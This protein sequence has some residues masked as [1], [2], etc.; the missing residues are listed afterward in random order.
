VNHKYKLYNWHLEGNYQLDDMSVLAE[1]KEQALTLALA[2][3]NEL[4]AEAIQR[5]KANG[6]PPLLYTYDDLIVTLLIDDNL[7]IHS[8]P[9]ALYNHYDG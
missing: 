8:I 3:V 2:K 7:S 5:A 9:V 4:I 1:S 6:H